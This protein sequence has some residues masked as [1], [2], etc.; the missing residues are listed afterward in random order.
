VLD[1]AGLAGQVGDDEAVRVDLGRFA[2]Q[3]Q[4]QLVG[5]DRAPPTRP[6]IAA[7]LAWVDPYAPDN[8]AGPFRPSRRDVAAVGDLGGVH[9]PTVL[10]RGLV[11]GGDGPPG[12]GVAFRGDPEIRARSHCGVGDLGVE[13]P[14][15]SPDPRPG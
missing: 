13:V 7:D 14:G 12:G 15:I 6:R 2:F 10:P 4:R 5:A 11:H 9:V 8:A 1:A 3:G